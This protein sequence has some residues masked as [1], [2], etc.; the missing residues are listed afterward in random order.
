MQ[1]LLIALLAVMLVVTVVL[2]SLGIAY[3]KHDFVGTILTVEH[4]LGK[5]SNVCLSLFNKAKEFFLSGADLLGS[6]YDATIGKLIA[7]FEDT[8][9][10]SLIEAFGNA[11]NGIV[12]FFR[13]ASLIFDYISRY[14]FKPFNSA[15]NAEF[16]VFASCLGSDEFYY[17]QD[18]KLLFDWKKFELARDAY[19]YDADNEYSYLLHKLEI[20]NI[21]TRVNQIP[22]ST[23]FI[24]DNWVVSATEKNY[25]YYLTTINLIPPEDYFSFLPRDVRINKY[26][27][28]TI[29]V[30]DSN[31]TYSWHDYEMSLSGIKLFIGDD[32]LTWSSSM[33]IGF[34][35]SGTV[36][37]LIPELGSVRVVFVFEYINPA[38]KV[39][40]IEVLP[41]EWED[42][43][44]GNFN[45][46][47]YYDYVY[48]PE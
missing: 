16:D 17:Y 22:S 9:D 29:P 26:F 6:I 31:I 10:V 25:D 32:D 1:K 21:F 23:I 12:E 39:S 38:G 30:F 44:G 3:S 13:K 14:G 41:G 24:A 34:G 47:D 7:W 42:N 27:A 5:V 20:D 2:G 15:Y 35:S 43:V 46:V 33:L 45:K 37:P 40:T 8:F 4:G 11:F 28:D 18:N 19:L 36:F 48:I